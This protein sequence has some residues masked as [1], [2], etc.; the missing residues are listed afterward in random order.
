M[1]IRDF[2]NTQHCFTLQ[3]KDQSIHLFCKQKIFDN[4]IVVIASLHKKRIRAFNRAFDNGIAVSLLN[5]TRKR[6]EHSLILYTAS[7]RSWYC[8]TNNLYH[9]LDKF[10]RRQTE[11][12]L[13]TLSLFAIPS[14]FFCVLGGL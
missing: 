9:S 2:A 14:P 12:I 11:D 7:I 13:L 4:G 5:F 8:R 10:D 1:P 3:E 6:S